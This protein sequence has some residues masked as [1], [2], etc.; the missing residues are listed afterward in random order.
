MPSVH[1]IC[2][3]PDT[4]NSLF[5]QIKELDPAAY[6]RLVS[7]QQEL[8][9]AR[10]V[11][12][13]QGSFDFDREDS[14]QAPEEAIKN[15]NKESI[16]SKLDGD[17]DRKFPEYPERNLTEVEKNRVRALL[18]RWLSEMGCE[19]TLNGHES[20]S[21]SM[22]KF[23]VSRVSLV[24]E[25]KCSSRQVNSSLAW[26]TMRADE[27]CKA[28]DV[29]LSSW[30]LAFLSE[31]CGGS[32][33]TVENP[34][35]K[36]LCEFTNLTAEKLVEV[37]TAFR[38]AP[39]RL[40]Y[41]DDP[42]II[43][44]AKCE[45]PVSND[46]ERTTPA[47]IQTPVKT[48]PP[49]THLDD[50]NFY[51]NPIKEEVRQENADFCARHI[52]E[53]ERDKP[54]VVLTGPHVEDA[55]LP[56]IRKGFRN[57][58]IVERN[59]EFVSKIEQGA[60]TLRSREGVKIRVVQ[61]DLADFIESQEVTPRAVELDSCGQI[62]FNTRRVVSHL[63][64]DP[65]LV[66]ITNHLG[67]REP[68]D[69]QLELDRMAARV[70]PLCGRELYQL[71]EGVRDSY[72]GPLDPREEG[73]GQKLFAVTQ[74][75]MF[76]GGLTELERQREFVMPGWILGNMG[77][78]VVEQGTGGSRSERVTKFIDKLPI[79]SGVITGQGSIIYSRD[80]MDQAHYVL[81][82]A[83]GHVVARYGL[84]EQAL[85]VPLYEF[86][87]Y[88]TC[89][90]GRIL[91]LKDFEHTWY[92][93]MSGSGRSPFI[94]RRFAVHYPRDVYDKMEVAG[95][96]SKVSRAVMEHASLK[97]TF[98]RIFDGVPD[99]A[100]TV[101][102]GVVLI[103]TTGKDWLKHWNGGPPVRLGLFTKR[104]RQFVQDGKIRLDRH[105]VYVKD[106]F[107]GE[108]IPLDLLYSDA[109]RYHVMNREYTPAPELLTT[110][111][112]KKVG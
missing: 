85:Q 47:A 48:S 45:V 59:G 69:V 91:K 40:V 3:D 84:P 56:Y 86:G 8:R 104:N 97:E 61:G 38:G 64:P 87:Q 6:D 101:P 88:A 37:I 9:R 46:S 1:N 70:T 71:Y 18:I 24:E 93:S 107:G 74:D 23:F 108:E 21:A 35:I 16:F 28:H 13:L 90:Y 22:E 5:T 51:G 96:F 31:Y 42:S 15:A 65:D 20:L 26:I 82:T 25:L 57:F 79:T 49:E 17:L 105:S 19:E 100:E 53:M 99:L 36:E 106:R 11:A 98:V 75:Y 52:P 10:A 68:A 62:S 50:V 73:A 81:G 109:H 54:F 4:R 78:N 29:D 76:D 41:R 55:L 66:L 32:P 12:E 2:M 72:L 14:P 94:T 80:V 63:G 67:K 110:T 7:T 111:P 33:L 27:V 112:L 34:L 83:I 58:V 39:P 92:Q 89:T 30:K 43:E 44:P 102:Q 77:L 60:N 95:H 103:C